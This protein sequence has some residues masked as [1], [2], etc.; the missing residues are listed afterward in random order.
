VL[1]QGMAAL[2]RP[3]RKEDSFFASPLGKLKSP[4]LED[5]SADIGAA[6][7]QSMFNCIAQLGPCILSFQKHSDHHH[8]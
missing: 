5:L 3:N 2:L 4:A 7:L 8:E 6:L 1:R